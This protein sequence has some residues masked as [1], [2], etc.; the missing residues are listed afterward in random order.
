MLLL[1]LRAFAQEQISLDKVNYI[2]ISPEAAALHDAINYPL[3]GNKGVPDISI[4]LY[5]IKYGKISIPITL[6][7]T[8]SAAKIDKSTAPNA[9]FGWVLDVGGCINRVIRGKPDESA[10]WYQADYSTFFNQLRANDDQYT[11]SGI[12]DWCNT[13]NNYDSE[14][15]EFVM[16]TPKG[17]ASFYLSGSDGEYDGHFSPSVNWKIDATCRYYA[18]GG[19]P[20]FT[21]IDILDGE[22]TKYSFGS[23]SGN[24]TP[25]SSDASFIEYCSYNIW[26]NGITYSTGWQLREVEDDAGNKVKFT[27]TRSGNY[28][29]SSCQDQ[30]YEVSDSPSVLWS[31]DAE[32]SQSYL[33][34]YFP[35]GN[36]T[37]FPYSM[38]AFRNVRPCTI[39][40]PQGSVKVEVSNSTRLISSILICDRTGNQIRKISFLTKTNNIDNEKPLLSSVSVKDAENTT[41][42]IYSFE[43]NSVI[44]GTVIA[45]SCDWWGYFNG[46][47]ITQNSYLPNR[48]ISAQGYN[49]STTFH[50]G[51]GGDR[52]P[53]PHYITHNIL[54]SITYPGGGSTEFVFEPNTYSKERGNTVPQ[55]IGPG[56]RIKTIQYMDKNG[57]ILKKLGYTYTDGNIS[58]LPDS[59]YTTNSTYRVY[60]YEYEYNPI[61]VIADRIRTIT[62]KYVSQVSAGGESVDYET[63]TEAVF[64]GTIPLGFTK[65]TFHVSDNYNIGT[66]GFLNAHESLPFDLSQYHTISESLSY[67]NAYLIR[68]EEHDAQGILARRTSY[69]YSQSSNAEIT[70][71]GFYHLVYYDYYQANDD[72]DSR[73]IKDYWAINRLY[74][75]RGID[76]IP[77]LYYYIYTST[78]GYRYPAGETVETYPVSSEGLISNSDPFIEDNTLLYTTNYKYHYPSV[79]K[80]IRS[81]GKEDILEFKYP[82]TLS[83]NAVMDSLVGRHIVSPVVGQV[84]KVDSTFVDAYSVGYTRLPGTGTRAGFLFRPSSIKYSKGTNN[85]FE[86]RISFAEYDSFGNPRSIIYNSDDTENYIWSYSHQTPIA[87]VTGAV[88][89]E[90]YSTLGPSAINSLESAIYPFESTVAEALSLLRE[91]PEA[92]TEGRTIRP[93]YGVSVEY[94]PSGQKQKY[95]YDAFQR[96]TSVL[97]NASNVSTY[98]EY[99]DKIGAGNSYVKVSRPDTARASI[100]SV[101]LSRRR[102]ISK[103]YDGQYREKQAVLAYGSGTGKD[104]VLP[105]Y[106]YDAYGR[107]TDE[108]LQYGSTAIGGGYHPSYSSE[109]QDFYSINYGSSEAQYA[110]HRKC[111][112]ESPVGRVLKEYLPGAGEYLNCPTKYDYGVNESEEV[113]LWYVDISN[114]NVTRGSFYNAGTLRKEIV[115]NPDGRITTTFIDKNGNVLETRIGDLCTSYIFNDAG[116]LVAV[117]PPEAQSSA[118]TPEPST[119]YRYV[120][121]KRNRLIEKYLPDAGKTEY[122]YDAND[123]VV[124]SRDA[125]EQTRGKWRFFRYDRLGREVYSGMVSNTLSASNLRTLYKDKVFHNSRST[126]GSIEGYTSVDNIIPI[127]L[128]DV[129]MITY[130]DSYG[131]PGVINFSAASSGVGQP[132]SHDV[133]GFATGY[134]FKVLDGNEFTSSGIFLT[135]SLYYNS[136][137]QMI[138]EVGEIY[139]GGAK[140]F[141]RRSFRFRHQGEIASTEEF[142]RINFRTTTVVKKYRYDNAGRPVSITQSINGGSFIPLE[143]VNFDAIGRQ[144]SRELGN[145]SQTLNY[146]WDIRNRLTSINN[147]I[148]LDSGKFG[149]SY[150]Y[151]PGG[152]ISESRWAH[153]GSSVQSYTFDYDSYGRLISGEHSGGNSE[154]VNYDRN[155]NITNLVRT[156]ERAET[157]AYTY[158]SGTNRIESIR[159][160]GIQKN[161]THNADGTMSG[162]GL[163]DLSISYN[164]LKLPKIIS[165]GSSTLE[166]IYDASGK[167]LAVLQDGILKNLYCGDVVYDS[168]LVIDFILTPVGQMKRDSSSGAYLPQYNI[169]DHLGNVRA[170]VNQ[171]GAVL[172]STDYYPFGLAFSDENIS[173]NRY[174]F[175]GKE[176]EYYT[177]GYSYLGTL[178]YGARHYDPRIARWN[179]PDPMAEKYHNINAYAFCAGNPVNFIDPDGLDWV[180]ANGNKIKDHSAIK[181]YIFYDPRGE[182]KGFAKQS[183]EMYNQLED[184]YGKGSVA[185]SNVTTKKEFI[186]DWH[187]MA[188]PDIKE[189]NLNYHG[190]NQTVML[191]SSEEQ[192]ITATGDGKTNKSDTEAI[193]VQDLPVP[194]GKINDAQ[195]N[196]NTCKSNSR[197]QYKL[198]G[199][200]Q[201]LMEAFYKSTNFATVRG[202]SYG[203]SY[204]RRT[205]QP[206]PGHSWWRGTWDY[207]KRPVRGPQRYR[208][209]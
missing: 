173:N 189:V 27:Y 54:K 142:Q 108:W 176:L 151:L 169:T 3:D 40:W 118:S 69:K 83:G 11:I 102:T 168:G 86:T 16:I 109:Q 195:L 153:Y 148:S 84:K 8:T 163:R 156:G 29:Y 36:N 98:I 184:K 204:D 117:I 43:Y 90:L 166:Y 25:T 203:V 136:L 66:T 1:S 45:P 92:L 157:L 192:Y 122:V 199:S 53:D 72:M 71:L 52:Y 149:I 201:T 160:N 181:A 49:F 65:F 28:T 81:D 188:S 172:Q 42:Q 132:S 129:L 15:D 207:M 30:W 93:H 124:A 209:K 206:F 99:K 60:V 191:N 87:K 75:L 193:N 63:V 21:G 171:N 128:N 174:L 177:L 135:T 115:T 127:S 2:A 202:T 159:C 120:Y 32:A 76:G 116:L 38:T 182:G 82:F 150:T 64:N 74:R 68:K 10:Q 105:Y 154:T 95:I 22:G 13:I 138:Q 178:D 91:I 44:N 37:E 5:T 31:E 78:K 158:S 56:L 170:V 145:N 47:A 39:S 17:G 186:Q 175:N 123:R 114:S 146:S 183:K 24:T 164:M 107:V 12:Y 58:I 6:R 48:L 121:D 33:N 141:F 34:T 185:M 77:P 85:D 20:M 9:G 14:K 197:T 112:E 126:S 130:Y 61:Y 113:Q 205:L 89:N 46:T 180:D 26:G 125:E 198:K 167:K 35:S 67:N 187:D 18:P 179:V 208:G 19:V 131:Y 23:G 200:K 41:Q 101:A 104:L 80:H 140:G 70:N 161:Y 194:T 147:P 57:E 55:G 165:N 97:D 162:D 106:K 190:N 4:P 144:S 119:Y 139:T 50:L 152:N 59:Y 133:K 155:G 196:L 88:W 73:L 111:Y 51:N 62:P 7:Y 100:S 134:K 137:G 94:Y 110:R 96:L 79:S 143:R 103:Y